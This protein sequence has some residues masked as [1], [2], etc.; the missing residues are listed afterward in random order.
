M[1]PS[2]PLLAAVK[3]LATVASKAKSI[4]L[5]GKHGPA[6]TYM[7][8]AN[9]HVNRSEQQESSWIEERHHEVL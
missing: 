5:C 9:V 3:R 2:P 8:E 1:P 6:M 4:T 7:Y